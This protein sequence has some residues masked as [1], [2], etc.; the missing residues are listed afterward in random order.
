MSAY[1]IVQVDV[2]DPQR[3]Q[4]YR[5]M[6]PPTLEAYGGRFVVRGGQTQTLEGDWD[7]GRVVV[8]EFDSVERA[9]AWWNSEEYREPKALRQQTAHTQMIVVE[10]VA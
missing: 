1:I 7:P 6:V 9:K 10:G 5:E 8:L 3:Y 4:K 2:H